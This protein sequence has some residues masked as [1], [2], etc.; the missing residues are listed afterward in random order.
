MWGSGLYRVFGLLVR[1]LTRGG[2]VDIS[3]GN[4][5][6]NRT[7]QVQILLRISRAPAQKTARGACAPPGQTGR[8]PDK[9]KSEKD[10]GE[11]AITPQQSEAAT[12]NAQRDRGAIL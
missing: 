11:A 5:P 9:C 8:I 12:S 1:K 6:T 4:Y 10:G 3:S 2:G 7:I